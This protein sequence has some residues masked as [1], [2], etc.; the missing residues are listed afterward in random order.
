MRDEIEDQ[1]PV[2]SLRLAKGDERR[3]PIAPLQFLSSGISVK[4]L[5]CLSGRSVN[6][7]YP[8]KDVVAVTDSHERCNETTLDQGRLDLG[9]V[10][11]LKRIEKLWLFLRKPRKR[12]VEAWLVRDVEH[13][14]D[15]G[16]L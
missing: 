5:H 4:L 6:G 2:Q 11:V 7:K 8:R 9:P 14:R 15:F 3:I 16:K 12:A 1:S 10:L 13:H